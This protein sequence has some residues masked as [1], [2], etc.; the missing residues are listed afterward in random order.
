MNEVGS[1]YEHRFSEAAATKRN[2]TRFI[3]KAIQFLK[4]YEFDGCVGQCS[5]G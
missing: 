3:K 1:K 2:R 4:Q 5:E